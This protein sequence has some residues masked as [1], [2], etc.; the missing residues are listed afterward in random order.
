MMSYKSACLS[1][2]LLLI[3]VNAPAPAS[4][5]GLGW[6]EW[7]VKRLLLQQRD[8]LRAIESGIRTM[9]EAGQANL[10]DL[11][12]A[13]RDRLAVELDLAESRDARLEILEQQIEVSRNFERVLEDRYQEG[14]GRRIDLLRVRAACLGFEIEHAR[15]KYG[16]HIDFEEGA[17]DP[18]L[19]GLQAPAE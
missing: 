6:E 13:T 12:H 14:A 4:P 1:A 16:L 7:Q 8:T 17:I 11:L 10:E 5:E 3:G 15:Q 9:R 18:S 2:V 19:L